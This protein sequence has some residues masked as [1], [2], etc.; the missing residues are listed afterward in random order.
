MARFRTAPSL[1]FGLLALTGSPVAGAGCE[2]AALVEITNRYIAAQSLGEIRYMKSLSPNATYTENFKKTE[3]AGGILKTPLKIDFHRSIHDTTACST[4]TEV[5]VANPEHL[6]V[7]GTQM[8][9]SDGKVAEI[10]SVV[11][12]EGDW[13]FN[14]THT[15]HYSLMENWEPILE[16]KRDSRKVLQ[17]AADAYL[18]LFKGGPGTVEVPWG[19]ECKRLE[20]G[21]YTAE[22][23]TCNSG[24]PSGVELVDRKYV[25]D[26]VMGVVDVFLKF[27]GGEGGS[28]LPD[29]HEFRVEEGKLRF[30]HTI[31]ACWEA[32]C[33]FGDPPEQ[34][35]QDV[36]H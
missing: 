26:E 5:V 27:G 11:T 8:R 1:L 32:N 23:D 33:G 12:D 7:I 24:V 14:A 19:A 9:I 17:A 30:I 3:L 34:L 16:N 15:L 20:G 10:E 28:G 36:G 22:G 25:I 21:L 4:F 29:S 35:K 13:L 31:T 18:D 2:R 6:Y